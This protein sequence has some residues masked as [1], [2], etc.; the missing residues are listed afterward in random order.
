MAKRDYYEVLGVP[1]NSSKDDIKK[2]YRR[3]AVTNHP[4]K[5]P[6]DKAAEERF[7]EATEAYEVL[8][9]DQKRSA[10]DQFGFAGVD[11]MG[12]GGG[13]HDFSNIFHDFEDIFGGMG[14]GFNI[15]ENL[16]G[17]MGGGGRRSRGETPRG[18]N[19][20]YDLELTFEQAVFGTSVEIAYSHEEACLSCKGSGSETGGGRKVCPTCQGSGQVRRSS[21]FFSIASPCPTCGGEGHI[22]DK[23]CK[24]CSGSGLSKKKQKI[25]VTIP[26]GV[27]DGKRL[28]VPGQGDAGPNGGRPGDLYV[29]IH[30][31]PHEFFERDGYDLYCAVPIGIAQAALGSEI[32]VPTIDGKKVK[33]S[34]PA[35]TQHGKMLR[36]REE[37]VPGSAGGAR[38]GDMYIKIMLQVPQKLSKRGKE[39][40]EELQKTEGANPEPRPIKLSDLK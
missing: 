18:S 39:L 20:R 21:G 17:G 11:G 16:F 34:V 8:G 6:G 25:K 30:V 28:S 2:A 9:D 38:R 27:D 40:L 36:L 22:V 19:L 1:K 14:G 37:G 4:D 13:A 32:T 33:V 12:A 15:F 23:P 24:T 31:R 7:K 29:F 10:Y 5:N 3:A 26:P 35:G